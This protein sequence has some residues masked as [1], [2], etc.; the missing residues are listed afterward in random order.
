MSDTRPV[1]DKITRKDG[2][3]GQIAYTATV[4]YPGSPLSQTTFV[5]SMYGGPVVIIV[6]H[7]QEQF[8]VD[9]PGRFGPFGEEWVRRFYS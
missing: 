9:D 6:D 2:L 7:G 1:V 4:H 8:F 3:A 5:G